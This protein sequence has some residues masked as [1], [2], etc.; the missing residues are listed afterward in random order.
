M[1]MKDNR[2]KLLIFGYSIVFYD[3]EL[4]PNPISYLTNHEKTLSIN[5]AQYGS[6]LLRKLRSSTSKTTTQQ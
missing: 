6:W 2:M 1:C 4:Y 5:D 3:I